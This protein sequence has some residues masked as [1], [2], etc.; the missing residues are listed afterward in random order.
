MHGRAQEQH[1]LDVRPNHW[2][3]LVALGFALLN[4]P[5][6][7]H[8]AGTSVAGDAPLSPV[9]VRA[10]QELSAAAKDLAVQAQY[11]VQCASKDRIDR[12]CSPEFRHVG[13]AQDDHKTEV[14]QF[15][16]ACD[17]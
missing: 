7:I 6:L 2:L 16:G 12:D 17:R 15:K 5:T 11:L 13:H 14:A 4:L 1:A 9:C 10:R 8:A 3:S